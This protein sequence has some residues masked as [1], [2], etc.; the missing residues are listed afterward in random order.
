MSRD[1]RK[2]VSRKALIIIGA[3]VVGLI[4]LLIAAPY[5][6]SVDHYRPAIE[7]AASSALGRQVTVGRLRVSVL[8]RTATADDVSIADDPA[9]SRD[10]FLQAK[11]VRVGVELLPLL[12]SHR[13]RVTSIT[14]VEPQL[15]VL[16]A[17]PYKWNFASIGVRPKGL[18]SGPPATDASTALQDFT[19]VNL[20]VE[21]G[22][23][24]VG[25]A[26]SKVPEQSYEDINLEAP[27]V[28][29]TSAFPVAVDLRTSGAGKITLEGTAGPIDSKGDSKGNSNADSKVDSKGD[30]KSESGVTVESVVVHLKFHATDVPAKGMEG[31]LST[32][33]ISLPS[34]AA[35]QR[36]SINADMT[37]DGALGHLVAN[38]PVG[39]S[40]VNVSGFNLAKWVGAMAKVS[41]IADIPYTEIQSMQS[42]V[43]VAPD[44]DEFN[45]LKMV[46]PNFGTLDGSGTISSSAVV[47]FKMKAKLNVKKS[48]L[49]TLRSVASLGQQVKGDSDLSFRVLGTTS[50]PV[51]VPDVAGAVGQTAALPFKGVGK[52]FSKLTGEKKPPPKDD[53]NDS[54]SK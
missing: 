18:A 4:L 49:G 29:V 20:R 42:D 12:F 48:P 11:D 37:V 16:R 21:N 46:L 26:A 8:R 13:V 38:G 40:D 43:R 54:R 35:F 41:G 27:R 14:V 15:H 53:S 5:F 1:V 6:V 3:S 47:N 51:F 17:S 19:V 32:L 50:V 23:L 31:L 22:K 45:N 2:G 10:A 24:T 30:S 36:G 52:I 33:N 25:S 44:G 7:S 9:F 28:S 39:F 34:G